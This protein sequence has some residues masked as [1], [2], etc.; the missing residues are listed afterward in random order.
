MRVERIFIGEDSFEKLFMPFIED[1]I[2]RIV[3]REPNFQY[4]EDNNA[5]ISHSKGVA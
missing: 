1:A 3:E 5:N 4:N 2:D